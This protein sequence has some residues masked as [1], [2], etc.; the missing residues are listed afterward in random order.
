MKLLEQSEGVLSFIKYKKKNS[1]RGL[2]II[3]LESD[4]VI[5]NKTAGEDTSKGSRKTGTKQAPSLTNLKEQG[6]QG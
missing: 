4:K 1:I 3:L 6:T 2:N 5:D